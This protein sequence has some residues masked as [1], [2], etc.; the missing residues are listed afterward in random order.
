MFSSL[1]RGA[2]YDTSSLSLSTVVFV[3]PGHPPRRVWLLADRGVWPVLYVLEIYNPVVHLP[4]MAC[5]IPGDEEVMSYH[6]G[7]EGLREYSCIVGF[8]P[9]QPTISRSARREKM[10][11]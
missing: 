3:P 2:N 7:V 1:A 8:T 9:A 5:T 10:K 6:S 11:F 4:S